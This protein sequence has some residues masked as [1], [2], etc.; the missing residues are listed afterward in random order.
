MVGTAKKDTGAKGGKVQ[1]KMMKEEGH[2]TRS[3]SLA[4]TDRLRGTRAILP[5]PASYASTWKNR[6][7]WVS[8]GGSARRCASCAPPHSLSFSPPS[9]GNAPFTPKASRMPWRPARTRPTRAQ[10]L[11]RRPLSHYDPRAQNQE[12]W[13]IGLMRPPPYLRRRPRPRLPYLTCKIS[14]LFSLGRAE[15]RT[16]RR[17]RLCALRRRR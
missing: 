15:T 11:A 2:S 1:L 13:T 7:R 8:N 10:T 16:S 5:P 17:V 9:P 3:G 6:A 4:S 14:S 12:P